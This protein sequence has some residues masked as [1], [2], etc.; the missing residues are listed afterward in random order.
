MQYLYVLNRNSYSKKPR[1]FRTTYGIVIRF[2]THD[3]FSVAQQPKTGQD[4]LFLDHTHLDTETLQE[5][6]ERVISSLQRLIPT[7]HTTNKGDEHPCLQRDSN[8]RFQQSSGCR[9]TH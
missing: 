2:T 3:F 9:P 5:F 4:R 6:S 8:P 1:C 7:Q